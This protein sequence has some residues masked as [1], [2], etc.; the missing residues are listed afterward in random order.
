METLK[1]RAILLAQ[2]H[3]TL[4]RAA[5]AFSYTPS[6]LSHMTDA[7]EEELGVPLLVRTRSGVHLTEEGELLREKLQAVLDAEQALRDAATAIGEGKREQLRIGT[8]SSIANYILPGIVKRFKKENP[9]VRVSITVADTMRGRLENDRSDV[10]FAD[11]VALTEHFHE[12]IMKDPFV[13]VVP[14]GMFPGRRA[15][16]CE[17]LYPY[18]YISTNESILRRYFDENRFAEILRFDS[19]DDHS[20][21]SMVKE[22]I[23]VAVLPSLATRKTERGVRILRLTPSISRSIGFAYHRKTPAVERFAAFMKTV[24]V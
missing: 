22:G 21:L 3:K 9:D 20:V 14:E 6:A 12:I 4:S 18:S 8:Y 11:E 15:V 1:I 17:E 23:G 19:V 13:A 2:Q 5:E 16:S 7:L 10:V 24:K